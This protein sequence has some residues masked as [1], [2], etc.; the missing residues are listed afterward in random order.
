MDP[1]FLL[2]SPVPYCCQCH[3]SLVFPFL[4]VQPPLCECQFLF[5]HVTS[6]QRLTEALVFVLVLEVSVSVILF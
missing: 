5:L 1:A 3:S 4:L 6:F 2:F